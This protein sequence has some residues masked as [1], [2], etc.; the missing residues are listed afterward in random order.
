MNAHV[1][2]S[3]FFI[4]KLNYIWAARGEIDVSLRDKFFNA[5]RHDYFEATI[6]T[7]AFANDV[8][9]HQFLNIV[10]SDLVILL[11]RRLLAILMIAELHNFFNVVPQF[12]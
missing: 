4:G 1:A 5:K 6:P 2:F 9:C 10:L 3:F 11:N 7:F 12:V 8:C